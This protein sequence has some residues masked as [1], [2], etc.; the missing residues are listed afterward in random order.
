[1]P[2]MKN[3]LFTSKHSNALINVV[4][5]ILF[6]YT[7]VHLVLHYT[8]PTDL[9]TK[10]ARKS[11]ATSPFPLVF[12]LCVKPAY[13][14]EVFSSHGY[15]DVYDFFSGVADVGGQ[16]AFVGWAGRTGSENATGKARGSLDFNKHYM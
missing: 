9:I 15:G 5:L 13:D 4:C 3:C 14:G 7:M 2:E 12:K 6:I 10:V 1:M 11:L 8:R 16:E